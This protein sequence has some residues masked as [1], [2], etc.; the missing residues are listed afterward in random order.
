[1]MTARRI[2]VGVVGE[3]IIVFRIEFENM[4]GSG[5]GNILVGIFLLS[6]R[7]S[8]KR[9]AAASR[10]GTILI[11]NVF[12]RSRFF[13]CFCGGR[14]ASTFGRSSVHTT[15]L[16]MSELSRNIVNSDIY[17]DLTTNLPE[18]KEDRRTFV[19]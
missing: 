19:F 13:E 10:F 5:V 12:F 18:V 4:N 17:E 6:S 8:S 2:G 7:L 15:I 3:S 11:S 16:D 14:C 1:M 9:I